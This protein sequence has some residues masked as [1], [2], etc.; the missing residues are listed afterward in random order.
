MT[1]LTTQ[2]MVT[3]EVTNSLG[4]AAGTTLHDRLN[5]QSFQ[6]GSDGNV[7][8]TVPAQSAIIVAP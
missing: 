1:R 5:G 8:L 7:T 6:V 3:V 4:F 2:Q